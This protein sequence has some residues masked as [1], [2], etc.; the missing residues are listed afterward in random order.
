MNS[1]AGQ[2]WM[3]FIPGAVVLGIYCARQ[4]YRGQW[5]QFAVPAAAVLV[6]LSG[7]G[8][9]TADSVRTTPVGL[10]AVAGSFLLFGLGTVAA[11][12]RRYWHQ[13]EPAL[14]TE[15]PRT[16]EINR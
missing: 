9:A 16:T 4:I 15:S 12:T 13:H 7:P 11:L 10:L 8:S 5:N 6:I 3:P 1:N 2:F 14:E